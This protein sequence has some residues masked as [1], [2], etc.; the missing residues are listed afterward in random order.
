MRRIQDPSHRL[1]RSPDGYLAGV[2]EGVGQYFDVSPNIIRLIWAV[3]VLG[4][5]TGIL[6]YLLV[7]WILPRADELPLEPPLENLALSEQ[8]P[9]VRTR[10]D[11]K[12][13]GVCGGVARRWDLDPAVVRLGAVGFFTASGGL[14]TVVYLVTALFMGTSVRPPQPHPVEL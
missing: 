13:L 6:L 7:W 5:G 11:R 4:F 12:I 8:P 9:L 10:V 3:A 1:T 14:A 2:C